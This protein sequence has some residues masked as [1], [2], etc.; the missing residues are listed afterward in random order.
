MIILLSAIS[1]KTSPMI[2]LPASF[3]F[4]LRRTTMTNHRKIAKNKSAGKTHNIAVEA[5][6]A[7]S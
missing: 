2:Y 5:F 1:S 3:N 6:I 4:S 7:G